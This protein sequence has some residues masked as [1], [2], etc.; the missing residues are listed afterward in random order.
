MIKLI[1]NL[2]PGAFVRNLLLVCLLSLVSIVFEIFSISL[3]LQLISSISD[4]SVLK[5][6]YILY[7]VNFLEIINY[8]GVGIFVQEETLKLVSAMTIF[9]IIR[10]IF[11]LIYV[12]ESSKLTYGIERELQKKIFKNYLKSD[13]LFFLKQNPSYLLRNVINETNQFALGI[14]GTIITLFTEII[15]IIFLL[16]LAFMTNAIF[17]TIFSLFFLSIGLFFYIITKKKLVEYGKIRLEAEGQKIKNI[18]EGFMSIVE[19]KIMN[20]IDIFLNLFIEQANKTVKVNIR[21][22]FIR[23]LPKITLELIAIFCIFLIFFY[24]HFSGFNEKNVLPLVAALSLIF[25]RLMPSVSKI[26]VSF[27]S[28]NISKKSLET[29]NNIFSEKTNLCNIKKQKFIENKFEKINFN[30][31]IAIKNIS[32]SYQDDSGKIKNILSTLSLDIKKNKKIGIFGDSGSGKSTLLKILLGLIKA[33]NGDIFIDETK[34]S[35][36]NVKSWHSRIGY[37]SQN[38]SILDETLVFNITFNNNNYDKNYLVELLLKM[39]LNRFLLNDIDID[40][41]EIG[42]KGSKIS[43]GE[44]QRI[45]MCRALYRKPDI[46]ILDEP[47]SS[48]DET[49]QNKILDDIFKMNNIT[50]ILVSHILENFQH[51]DSVYKLE[52]KSII[53]I[54]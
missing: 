45:G 24:L 40:N 10:S 2:I 30:S 44:R 7:L 43:G 3:M 50:V 15:L 4:T 27:Q 39:N 17:T 13:Y 42:D 37:V 26:I 21:Y 6:T 20:L 25:I 54:K 8:F 18:Q 5:N 11:S 36:N 23:N 32:F 47:T 38:T 16:V 14:V 35:E 22:S 1:Y 41:F 28:F 51:C 31:H 33:D 49:T 52:N 12:F 53:K 19:I 9:F 46:L 34:L 48:L 29:L